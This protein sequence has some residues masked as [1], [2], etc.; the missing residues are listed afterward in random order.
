L[1]PYEAERHLILGT[2]DSAETL[3]QLEYAWYEADDSHTAPLYAARGVL[4]YLLVGNLRAANKYF[5]LFTSRLSHKANL[6]MQEVSTS[7]SDLKVYPSLPLLNFL[8]LL[9]LAVERGEAALYR[10]LRSH[11]A[12]NLSDVNWG[13]ALDKIGEMYFGISIPRQGNPMMDMLGNMFMGGGLGGG[14]K[15]RAVDAPSTP[16]LD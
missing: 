9:L 5:L 1:E 10:Q 4:P 16:G 12:A 14:K 15:G 6:G 13:E 2:K 7:S 8:G 11:Y 3:A